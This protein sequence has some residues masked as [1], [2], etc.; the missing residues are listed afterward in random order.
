MQQ[1][2]VMAEGDERLR[3]REGYV[4]ELADAERYRRVWD[5]WDQHPIKDPVPLADRPS[6]YSPE[7]VPLFRSRQA[8]AASRSTGLRA[9]ALLALLLL[10]CLPLMV[11]SPLAAPLAWRQ[12]WRDRQLGRRTGAIS[13]ER[14]ATA[15]SMPAVPVVATLVWLLAA[16]LWPRL[17]WAPEPLRTAAVVVAAL[18]ALVALAGPTVVTYLDDKLARLEEAGHPPTIRRYRQYRQIVLA[19]AAATTAAAV[20][21]AGVAGGVAVFGRLLGG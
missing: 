2:M 16:A 6:A 14:H 1:G 9:Y 15:L 19:L 4:Y 5:V 21:L 10:A 12:A 8:Q 3:D 11:L 17:A 20:F 13:W 7:G 18:L